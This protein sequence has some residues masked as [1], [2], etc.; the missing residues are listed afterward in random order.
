MQ[1]IVVAE[2]LY[3]NSKMMHREAYQFFWFETCYQVKKNLSRA[4]SNLMCLQVKEKPSWIFNHIF[5]TSQEE[6][7]FSSI[8]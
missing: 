3:M 8:N 6:N 7:S 5:N 1:F 4:I 2:S